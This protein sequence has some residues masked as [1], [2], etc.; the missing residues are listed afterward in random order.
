[1]NHTGLGYTSRIRS[2]VDS[3]KIGNHKTVTNQKNKSYH[4][5]NYHTYSSMHH[6]KC[7][8]CHKYGHK[9]A[10]C[11]YNYD[12]YVKS[13]IKK[14]WVPKDTNMHGPK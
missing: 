9:A 4:H 8:T 7:F 10:F 12:V 5:K 3:K 11:Y 2:K 1:M 14:I 13:K 6:I